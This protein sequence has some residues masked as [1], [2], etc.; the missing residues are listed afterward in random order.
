MSSKSVHSVFIYIS[1]SVP[2][3]ADKHCNDQLYSETL[4]LYYCNCIT[5]KHSVSLSTNI[6]TGKSSAPDIL[7]YVRYYKVDPNNLRKMRDVPGH[8]FLSRLNEESQTA[9]VKLRNTATH[10]GFSLRAV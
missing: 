9:A 10:C 4:M 1:R 5:V 3:L 6:H 8:S 2:I 7:M